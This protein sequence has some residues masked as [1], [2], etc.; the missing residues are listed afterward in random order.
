MSKNV[1]R[2]LLVGLLAFVVYPLSYA[3]LLR[4]LSGTDGS[5]VRIVATTGG[6]KTAEVHLPSAPNWAIAYLPVRLLI[7]HTP[8]KK[9]LLLWADIWGVD[10][11]Q[12]FMD[13]E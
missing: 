3:P 7:T 13:D 8:L 4:L 6:R 12:E 11:Q 9:P 2:V 1:R 10:G 5:Y